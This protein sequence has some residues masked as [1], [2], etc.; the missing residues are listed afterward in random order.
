M[1]PLGK[2]LIVVGLILVV[3]GVA[4]WVLPSIPY[5][6]RLGRL[7]GDIYIKRDNFTLYFPLTTG[8]LISVVLTILLSLLRR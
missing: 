3:A 5:A 7:P 4:V 6:G 1:P 8:I 2:G